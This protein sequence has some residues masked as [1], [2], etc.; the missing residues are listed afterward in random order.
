M[1]LCSKIS[2]ITL[3]INGINT[4]KTEIGRMNRKS[5]K[6]DPSIYYRQETQFK[7]YGIGSMKGISFGFLWKLTLLRPNLCTKNAPSFK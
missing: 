3:N 5:I 1:T 2:T 7:Y 4:Q 6:H